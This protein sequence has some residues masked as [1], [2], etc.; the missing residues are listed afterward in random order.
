MLTDVH[1]RHTFEL[2]I[3]RLMLRHGLVNSDEG[4]LFW[5]RIR[6]GEVDIHGQVWR[7]KCAHRGLKS[8]A[9]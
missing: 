8:E 3:M 5:T 9:G 1:R 7:I 2:A 4:A 6:S